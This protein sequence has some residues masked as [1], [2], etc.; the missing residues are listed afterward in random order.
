MG[1]YYCSCT[2]FLYYFR[3]LGRE[4]NAE[5]LQHHYYG[6]GSGEDVV[7]QQS[8]DAIIYVTVSPYSCV[9]HAY[10]RVFQNEG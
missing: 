8:K 9:V 2:H 7:V 6:G 1:H 10:Y 3:I 5:L 4:C